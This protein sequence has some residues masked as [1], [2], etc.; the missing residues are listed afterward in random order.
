MQVCV[1]L[2]MVRRNRRYGSGI[3]HHI[4]ASMSALLPQLGGGPLRNETIQAVAISRRSGLLPQAGA[5]RAAWR[6]ARPFEA[7]PGASR[8]LGGRRRAVCPPLLMRRVGGLLCFDLLQHR[9][10]PLVVDDCAWLHA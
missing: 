9:R 8:L 4:L 5:A 10:E 7:R 1:L 6:G 2:S 3:R